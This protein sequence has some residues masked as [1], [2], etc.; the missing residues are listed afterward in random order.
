NNTNLITNTM[1]A[2]NVGGL[3]PAQVDPNA[4]YISPAP[5]GQLGGRVSFFLPWQRHFD[6][7]LVK[8][9]RITERVSLSLRAQALDV[10]N[11]TNFLPD[12]NIGS[13]FGQVGGAYR[14]ISG[15]VDPGS[16]ILEFVAR[17]SEE[18][19]VGKECR[20]RWSPY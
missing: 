13:S 17:R 12:G 5:V 19:R 18:R 1:A 15:T 9:T 20:S 16:R 7:S 6:V 8:N 4:P 14:D 10:F 11:W 2:F 3:T